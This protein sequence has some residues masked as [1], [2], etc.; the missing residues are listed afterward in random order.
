MGAREQAIRI[1]SNSP[2][3]PF[4]YNPE[5]Q[6]FTVGDEKIAIT[7]FATRTPNANK[8]IDSRA[9]A[10]LIDTS[11]LLITP[12]ERI[13]MMP[14]LYKWLQEKVVGPR[15]HLLKT[16]LTDTLADAYASVSGEK[17]RQLP[18]D[19]SRW[20]FGM[21]FVGN[22]HSEHPEFVIP[23]HNVSMGI[24]VNGE[25][26]RDGWEEKFAEFEMHNSDWSAQR[27]ALMA[28]AGALSYLRD[29]EIR[30]N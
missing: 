18:E 28:G 14:T 15:L 29:A 11:N 26:G 27:V 4:S 24:A 5:D 3:D 22:I 8:P 7:D 23:G 21:G 1:F 6:H 16:Q 13:L 25:F 10:K 17:P 19:S 12:D 30:N 2:P 20:G 9:A